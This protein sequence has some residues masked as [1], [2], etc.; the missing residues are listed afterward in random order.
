[1]ENIYEIVKELNGVGQQD[2]GAMSEAWS[3]RVASGLFEHEE[4][5]EF[6]QLPQL[7]DHTY[8]GE[9]SLNERFGAV[10]KSMKSR[11]YRKVNR[12]FYVVKHDGYDHHGSNDVSGKF[13]SVNDAITNFVGEL[14]SS[15]L[16]ESTVLVMGSDF[17][18]SLNPNSNGGSDVSS[19]CNLLVI[20]Y[21]V[22]LPAHIN[23]FVC[24]FVTNTKWISML[25]VVITSCLEAQSEAARS[26]ED[27]LS[28]SLLTTLTG[29]D[30]DA[31]F[32]QHLGMLSG[33]ALDSGWV[34]M[35][36]MSSMKPFPIVEVLIHALSFLVTRTSSLMELVPVLGVRLSPGRQQLH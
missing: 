34:F 31:L 25:G 5:I 29:L 15:G 2:N 1:M 7:S 6:A 36:K 4:A 9:G 23:L 10:M 12:E 3:S 21:H 22:I 24:I 30:V 19:L 8:P 33:M 35:T 14:K 16:Y 20:S 17:G 26:W 13:K 32:Q 18:R 27:T 11:G 28:H